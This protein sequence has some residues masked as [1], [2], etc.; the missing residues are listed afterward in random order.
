MLSN[1]AEN[2]EA[3][4]TARLLLPASNAM[5]RKSR[6]RVLLRIKLSLL[7]DRYSWLMMDGNEAELWLLYGAVV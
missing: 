7:A 2:I 4:T 6:Y 5:Q 1:T 3:D